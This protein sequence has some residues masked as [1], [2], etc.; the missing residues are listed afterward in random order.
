MYLKAIELKELILDEKNKELVR[1]YNNTYL[2]K[3]QKDIGYVI[4]SSK[5]CKLYYGQSK[6]NCIKLTNY[7]IIQGKQLF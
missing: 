3:T 5:M 6:F 2:Y 1:I 4:K 7:Q